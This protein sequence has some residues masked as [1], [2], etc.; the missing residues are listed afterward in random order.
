MGWFNDAAP[1][2]EG[3]TIGL[4]RQDYGWRELGPDDT[5]PR[6]DALQIECE[7]G[8]RSPRLPAPDGATW[9]PQRVCLSADYE[10][11]VAYR[12]WMLHVEA[13]ADVTR[14]GT[15]LGCDLWDIA[16]AL[17][18]RYGLQSSGS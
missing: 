8:W 13:A 2:H 4:R 10:D 14:V 17:D 9:V 16:A 7:C 11:N 1:G 18:Q 6:V 5:D 12:S 15:E 3:F